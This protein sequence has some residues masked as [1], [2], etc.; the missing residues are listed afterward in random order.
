MQ[1]R[2]WPLRFIKFKWPVWLTDKTNRSRLIL[3]LTLVV[4]MKRKPLNTSKWDG[5][6]TEWQMTLTKWQIR[7]NQ[8]NL[9]ALLS[10][11]KGTLQQRRLCVL[12]SK[13][14]VH[15]TDALITTII[16]FSFR[17]T[18]TH[19]STALT[20][21]LFQYGFSPETS[22]SF[23]LASHILIGA[24]CVKKGATISERQVGRTTSSHTDKHTVRHYSQSV[25]SQVSLYCV[26][27]PCWA[28]LRSD[29]TFTVFILL[30]VNKLYFLV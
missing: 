9:K 19:I 16:S 26:Y 4:T 5:C 11:D 17:Q 6:V 7:Q 24:W 23:S 21:N 30:T 13:S 12:C 20:V 1:N 29:C 2:P 18:V 28:A 15:S 8:I 10:A 27:P 3:C 25:C 22:L 14:S